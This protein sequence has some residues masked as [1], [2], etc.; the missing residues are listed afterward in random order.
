MSVKFTFEITGDK[1]LDTK[2]ALVTGNLRKRYIRQAFR[3]GARL[4]RDEARNRAPV[5]TGKLRRGIEVTD[6]R[7]G[8]EVIGA[9]V[10]TKKRAWF[11]IPK[12]AK[13][14]YPAIVEYKHK[15][16]LRSAFWARRSQA[17]SVMKQIMRARLLAFMSRR[18]ILL[19]P[20]E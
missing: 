3:A 7:K 19:R 18:S 10:R 20:I 4:I 17:L 13:W 1:S 5:R 14:Y 15:S 12:E 6:Y 11:G 9:R 16:F 2:L 8:R